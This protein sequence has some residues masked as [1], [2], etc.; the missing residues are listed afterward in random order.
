MDAAPLAIVLGGLVFTGIWVGGKHVLPALLGIG[1]AVALAWPSIAN[2][3]LFYGW[4]QWVTSKFDVNYGLRVEIWS[5]VSTLIAEHP[6]IGHGFGTGRILGRPSV[7]DIPVPVPFMH[8]HNGMLEMWL[9]L[10]LVGV[11]LALGIAAMIF[12]GVMALLSTSIVALAVVGATL[13]CSSVFWFVSFGLWA[14][15]WLA[16]LGLTAGAL[17]LVVRSSTAEWNT[18]SVE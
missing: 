9:E 12:C 17:A 11:M 2:H 4:D 15:W 6:L 1:I 16:A 3:A 14:G 5:R 18:K 13:A 8:P 7:A 10:G